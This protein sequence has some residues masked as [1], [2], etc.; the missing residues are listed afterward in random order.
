MTQVLILLCLIVANGLVVM[1]ELALISAKRSRL[2]SKAGKGDTNAKVALKLQ[3][4]PE[5]FLST[6]QIFITL[7]SILSGVFVE[8]LSKHLVPTLEKIAWLN[9]YAHT[10]ATVIVLIAITFLSIIIGELLPKRLS[11]LKPE[12][13]ARIVAKPM[14]L[15]S[16]ITYPVV[17][18]LNIITNFVFKVFNIKPSTDNQVTEE[19]IK[20]LINEGSEQG[21][22]EED[23]KEI[24]ERVI[25]LGDRNITSLMTHRTDIVWLDVKDNSD[26]VKNKIENYLHSVYPVCDG[27]IDNILGV[28][29]LKDLFLQPNAP[30]G[31]FVKKALIVPQNNSAYQLLE[32]FKQ[33]K[34]HYAFIV[35]EY[36]TLNGMVT[37]KDILTAIVGDIPEVEDDDYSIVERQD[38]TFL[39]DAQIQFYNFLMKFGQ[40]DLVNIDEYDFD[41]LA[42]FI[43]HEL[44]H[45]PQTGE[46]FSWK[47]FGFEI[48]DMDGHRID[49][50]LVKISDNIKEELEE[51]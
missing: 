20:A 24:I 25:H 30:L 4:K 28:I 44:K 19:E 11:I 1:S 47:G 29:Y 33:T 42:G 6:A 13:I 23:E 51:I 37:I 18:L 12:R 15:L 45:I 5:V 14:Q 31:D 21:A 40:T 10:A 43:L 46:T 27:E 17:W 26:L 7:I 34:I 9:P 22:I 35:D 2:E 36:G 50:I 38:G 16:R 39:V 3:E 41:T 8:N 49:K 48:I 32:K